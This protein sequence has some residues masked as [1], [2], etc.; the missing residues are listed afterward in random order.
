ML[1]WFQFKPKYSLYDGI[2]KFIDSFGNGT[3]CIFIII[4]N[5]HEY[6]D[7]FIKYHL[8]IGVNHIFIFEDY[9]SNTHKNIVEKYNN[10]TLFS[11]DIIKNSST[12]S[13]NYITNLMEKGIPLQ[14][15][16]IK[17]GLSYIK[18]HYNY[19][20]CIAIDIDEYITCD[21]NNIINTLH[22]YQM[23]DAIIL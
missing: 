4:K 22:N 20:W 2:N 10:V 21:D 12:E 11:V 17:Y 6:L 18:S 1:Q 19:N 13:N 5:E 9:N 8:N 7:D 3:C 23:Y 15:A 16:F 14:Q